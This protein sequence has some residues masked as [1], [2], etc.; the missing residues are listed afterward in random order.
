MNGPDHHDDPAPRRRG[1]ILTA[2]RNNFLA[3]LVVIAPI[4]MTFWLVTTVLGWVDGVDQAQAE[5]Q[6]SYRVG[7][8]I[9]DQM[10]REW[11]ATEN[12]LR[13]SASEMAS[14]GAQPNNVVVFKIQ[15]IGRF[16]L[17]DPLTFGLS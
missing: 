8:Y 1:G 2:F 14:I 10:L 15:Q 7:L 3:G 13:I 5:D 9:D 6:E 12:H 4:G 16:A 17:S 11:T